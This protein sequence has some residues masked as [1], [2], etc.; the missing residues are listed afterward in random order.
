MAAPLFD[1]G[2]LRGQLRASR[3][4]AAKSV[5]DYQQT[6]ITALQEVE[7]SL[8]TAHQQERV[9]AADQNAADAAA[10]AA[11]LA[12]AQYRLGTI[13]FLTVL[14][15]QRTRY[16]AEDTLVQAR[17]ARL[18]ASVSVF[19]AFGGGFGVT[20]PGTASLNPSTNPSRS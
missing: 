14:D 2:A 4:A 3:G 5:A 20:E 10:K 9:E 16:Q 7:D 12:E 1:G 15:A 18:Q 17:L 11:T 8:T 13:D 6:V 19:R